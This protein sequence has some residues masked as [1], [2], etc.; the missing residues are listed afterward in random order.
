MN[1]SN[2]GNLKKQY[3]TMMLKAP[4][5]VTRT[6]GAKA[7]AKKFATFPTITALKF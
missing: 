5:G 1:E 2:N 4:R 3:L 6:A 7:Y